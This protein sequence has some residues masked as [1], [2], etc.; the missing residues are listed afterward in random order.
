MWHVVMRLG[1]LG[2]DIYTDIGMVVLSR[3]LNCYVEE[4]TY[5][6]ILYVHINRVIYTM[7][8]Y[9]CMCSIY[10]IMY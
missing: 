3:Y 6:Y 7:D 10:N 5:A 9:V 1:N 4:I 8:I 2:S